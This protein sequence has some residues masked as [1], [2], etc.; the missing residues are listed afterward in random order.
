[1]YSTSSSGSDTVPWGIYTTS[2]LTEIPS[3]V[4]HDFLEYWSCFSQNLLWGTLVRCLHEVTLYTTSVLC[5]SSNA[6]VHLSSMSIEGSWIA[7]F[8]I[9]TVYH[10][11]HPLIQV[12][13]N[14]FPH[15]CL[16][17]DV[18]SIEVK[19]SSV[20]SHSIQMCSLESDCKL[21]L[22]NFIPFLT[23]SNIPHPC[24]V[25]IFFL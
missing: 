24:R 23:S 2:F 12:D 19:V 10:W 4:G 16:D 7:L 15:L 22:L 1:M 25:S 9:Q 8:W 20:W 17:C 6:I 3:S 18:Y 21:I 13:S 5:P 14:H 11:P